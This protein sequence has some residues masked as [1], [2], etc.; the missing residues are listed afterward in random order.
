MHPNQR[1]YL[2]NALTAF[3]VPQSSTCGDLIST[4]ADRSR[5]GTRPDPLRKYRE[6]GTIARPG[7][8]GDGA[9]TPLEYIAASCLVVLMV[10]AIAAAT[11]A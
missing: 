4:N 7:T 6:T 10:W 3:S 5:A 2:S 9:M 11:A 1:I 8:D